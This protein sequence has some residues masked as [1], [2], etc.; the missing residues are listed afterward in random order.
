M[1]SGTSHGRASDETPD[2][3]TSIRGEAVRCVTWGVGTA[4]AAGDFRPL[5]STDSCTSGD[6]DVETV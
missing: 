1:C 4:V 2:L 6:D 5:L 3:G